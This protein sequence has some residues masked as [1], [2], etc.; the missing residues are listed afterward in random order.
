MRLRRFQNFKKIHLS[1]FSELIA[2]GVSLAVS[3]E[4]CDRFL[5]GSDAASEKL[6]RS[7]IP[8]LTLLPGKCAQSQISNAKL[9]QSAINSEKMDKWIFLKFYNLLNLSESWKKKM[10]SQMVF[11]VPS[12]MSFKEGVR[13]MLVQDFTK[14]KFWIVFPSIHSLMKTQTECKGRTKKG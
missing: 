13:C 8:H 3:L 4:I 11:F 7:G 12:F 14:Q 6:L 9:T 10:V 1:I 5:L 2:L